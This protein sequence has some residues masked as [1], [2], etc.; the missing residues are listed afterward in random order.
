MNVNH[1]Q[2]DPPPAPV[3]IPSQQAITTSKQALPPGIP[4]E[5]KPRPPL[6][7][8]VQGWNVTGDPSWLLN[9]AIIGFPKT[10]TSTLMKYLDMAPQVQVFDE[11]RC[12]MGYNQHVRLMESL[13]RDMP[14]G[15]VIRGIKCPRDLEIPMA[16]KNYHKFFP[17]TDFMVGVRH[18][19]L[20]FE[21]FY[22]FRYVFITSFHCYCNFYLL[23]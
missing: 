3:I 5:P 16:I 10:G 15:D 4:R 18:P 7:S 17:N 13:Y 12:E 8:I 20:W 2:L 21:S 11:E 9:L 1:S 22:N 19:I 6:Q 14:P 23:S